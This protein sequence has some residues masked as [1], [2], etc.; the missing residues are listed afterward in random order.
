D[1]TAEYMTKR[2]Y[3][4]FSVV[5]R[6]SPAA[7]IARA[8]EEA[9]RVANER[10]KAF[11]KRYEENGRVMEL[12]VRTL[13]DATTGQVERPL[14]LLL[15][16]VCLLLLVACANVTHLFLARAVGRSSEMAVRRALGARTR[17]L[18]AQLLA[19]S[20]MLGVAGAVL[21]ALIAYA[22]VRAFLVLTPDGLP[23]AATISVDARVLFFAAAIGMLTAIVFGLMLAVRMAG[24]GSGDPLRDSGRTLTT[25]RGAQR[26]RS[27]LIVGEVAISLI[28][29]AQAGWLLRSF[30]RMTR[31]ELGFRTSGIVAIP[32]SLP[33]PRHSGYEPRG[34]SATAWYH[35][36]EAIRESLSQA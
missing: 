7:T 5:G 11:P 27:A 16:A 21:G 31:A 13:R 12:P 36:M 28:L 2:D 18:I 10:A 8:Q 35:R 15:G 17:S 1:P 25:S 22:G 26:L 20:G 24:S 6:L 34:Q 4:M 3:W 23:R 33:K 32:M 9:D 30:I 14:R 29:V 19:E